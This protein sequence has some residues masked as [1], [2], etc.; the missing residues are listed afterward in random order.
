MTTPRHT[1][2]SR[3]S[4]ENHTKIRQR[5][6]M[7]SF[8]ADEAGR[9]KMPACGQN[10]ASYNLPSPNSLAEGFL[11]KGRWRTRVSFKQADAK[12]NSWTRRNTGTAPPRPRSKQGRHGW[13]F[14]RHEGASGQKTEVFCFYFPFPGDG[15]EAAFSME[16]EVLIQDKQLLQNYD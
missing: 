12:A 13:S 5:D 11:H 9:E 10:Q 2:K 7:L 15:M 8:I 14:G 16:M 1:S 6:Q 3:A 4:W